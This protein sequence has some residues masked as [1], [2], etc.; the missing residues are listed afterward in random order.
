MKLNL[1]WPII[2]NNHITE[3]LSRLIQQKDLDGTY[4]FTG[5]RDLGKTTL[6]YYFAQSILC[7]NYKKGQG[8]LP[9]HL[10][11]SCRKID[12]TK[13][14][15]KQTDDLEQSLH[16]D[17]HIIKKAKDKKNISISQIRELINVLGMGSF[18]HSYKIGIIKYAEDLSEEAAN[19]FLKTLEEPKKKVIII[20]ITNYIE[21]LPKTVVSRSRVLNFQLVNPDIIYDYL[22]QKYNI[23]RSKA[24]NYSHLSLGRP[25][26]AV[27]FLEDQD[28]YDDYFAKANILFSIIKGD[29][30]EALKQIE[31]IFNNKAVG[32]ENVVKAIEILRIWQGIARDLL[33]F[34]LE[35][36]KLIQH[37][38]IIAQLKQVELNIN[39]KNLL[40]L[41]SSLDKAIEYAKANVNP[42][43]A[44][45]SVALAI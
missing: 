31:K 32:Q 44:L 23:T 45:E 3:Y 42:K 39:I 41:L 33:L 34:K 27:K 11:E 37:E 21:Y 20:L 1:S 25:A 26:L 7:D 36:K 14:Y 12:L 29:V 35:Q 43:T 19:A 38:T 5:P 24:K 40:K 4:I 16:G 30:N 15:A 10:C 13:K 2:G 9:C 28:F 17:F 6:A 18:L 8:T 22:I